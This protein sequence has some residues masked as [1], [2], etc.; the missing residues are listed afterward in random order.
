YLNSESYFE[1]Q[2]RL[3]LNLK[4]EGEDVIFVYRN[5]DS[6]KASSSLGETE[7]PVLSKLKKLFKFLMFD[8]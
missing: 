5:D 3:R 1:K 7:N 6:V 2:A 8:N 4:K